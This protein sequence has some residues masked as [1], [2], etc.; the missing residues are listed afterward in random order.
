MTPCSLV[1]RTDFS[2]EH[3]ATIFRIEVQKCTCGMWVPSYPPA[4]W[5]TPTNTTLCNTFWSPLY[6]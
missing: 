3:I 5:H 1:G 4:P 6:P 2:E